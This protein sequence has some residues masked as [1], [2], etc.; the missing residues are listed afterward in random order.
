VSSR[1]RARLGRRAAVLCTSIAAFAGIQLAGASGASAATC[2]NLPSQSYS[3]IATDP[4]GFFYDPSTAGQYDDGGSRANDVSAANDDSWDSWNYVFVDNTQ[5]DA[6]GLNCTTELNGRQFAYPE[7]DIAGLKV[8]RKVYVPSSGLAFGRSV[9]F[10]R[11]PSGAPITVQLNF[12]GNLGSDSFTLI[13]ATSSGDNA[14][15]DPANDSWAVSADSATA[16]DDA[17]LA[18]AWDSTAGT[19]VADRVDHIYGSSTGTTPWADAQ[20]EVRALYDNVTVPAG[21]T[22]AYMQIEAER[23]TVDEAK[24]AA[25]ALAASPLDVFAGLTDTELS[26]LRNWNGPDLDQDGVANTADN[27]RFVA[28]ADQADLDKDGQG[29]VCDDDIDGDTSSNADEAVRGTDPRKADTDG[30]GVRDK[31]DACPTVAG[32]GANGCPRFDDNTAPGLTVS[33]KSKLKRKTALKGVKITATTNEASTVLFELFGSA[34]NAHIAKSYNLVLASKTAKGVNG[35]RSVTL[36][37]KKSLVGKAKKFTLR[38]RVTATD[39]FGSRTVK[40][41]TISVK[42]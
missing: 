21:A 32:K 5:Y 31:A 36:K 17:T 13:L 4:L 19:G 37:P 1:H 16:P 40:T 29:D 30:D 24:Q 41:K 15:A 11:N 6:A 27:C 20:D 18:H 9:T 12:E 34:K 39:A 35:K 38:V 22:V 26:E 28:N 8:S 7:V 25:P 42:G 2:D 3:F 14:I 23:N 33:A 10:L